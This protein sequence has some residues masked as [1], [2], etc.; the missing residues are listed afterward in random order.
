MGARLHTRI[1]GLD[2]DEIDDYCD[3]LLVR[4]RH[5][6]AWPGPCHP[7]CRDAGRAVAKNASAA[8]G[9]PRSAASSTSRWKP[10]AAQAPK[11]LT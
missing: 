10:S 6:R 3:H 11:P 1:A 2:Y 9:A 4:N 5:R 7:C 8:T